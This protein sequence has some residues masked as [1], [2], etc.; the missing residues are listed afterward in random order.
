MRNFLKW[1]ILPLIFLLIF[2]SYIF[3]FQKTTIKEI[4]NDPDFYH[5][6]VVKVTGK[7][8]NLRLKVSRKGNPYTTFRLMDKTGNSLKVFI[9]EHQDLKEGDLVEVTGVFKRIKRVG[10]YTFFN[11]IE[12][13]RIKK[14][15][16]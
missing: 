16:K 6:K 14:I 2:P 5:Q 10:I 1:Q 8:K 12:A 13:E 15:S 11:E 9:W 4:L 3:S 7:I